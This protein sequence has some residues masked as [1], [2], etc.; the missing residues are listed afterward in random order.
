MAMMLNAMQI[1]SLYAKIGADTR[2]VSVDGQMNHQTRRGCQPGVDAQRHQ[3]R[4][5]SAPNAPGEPALQGNEVDRH[6]ARASCASAETSHPCKASPNA[7]TDPG[8][9]KRGASPSAHAAI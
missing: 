7:Q 4:A 5:P 8:P 1:A 6:H 2:R 9:S 3:P